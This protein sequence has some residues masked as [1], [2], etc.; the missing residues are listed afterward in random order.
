MLENWC[1][2]KDILRRIS[3]HKTTKQPLPDDL[4]ERMVKAKNACVGLLNR[5]QLFFG[6]FDIDIHTR[7]Q[8]D[9]L[10]ALYGN[11]R[12]KITKVANT[13]GTNGAAAWGHIFSGYDA[14]YYGYM[15]AEVY[16]CDM[17]SLFQ[18]AGIMNKAL[19]EKY[20][21]VILKKGGTL[22]GMDL[23]REFLGRDPTPKAFLKQ[24]NLL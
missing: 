7:A 16:S 17:F 13:P 2:E 22:D 24:K 20:R 14:T 18:E 11:M 6:K 4:L 5:R 19:G 23:L 8:V 12:T 21:N 15:W 9:D 1:W 3:Q 10:D